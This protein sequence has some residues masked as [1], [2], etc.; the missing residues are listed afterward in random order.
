MSKQITIDLD[1]Y[2]KTTDG[3]VISTIL[4]QRN[5]SFLF[6]WFYSIIDEQKHY[7]ALSCLDND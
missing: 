2:F 6:P 7:D 3:I 5:K 4:Y 1:N